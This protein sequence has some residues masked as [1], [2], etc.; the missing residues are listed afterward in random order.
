MKDYVISYSAIF[1]MAYGHPWVVQ[2][3]GSRDCWKF[4]TEAEA[5]DFVGKEGGRLVKVVCGER[6]IME[7]WGKGRA[8]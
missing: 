6:D 4:A 1:Q 3:E 7:K 8:V 5:R 2:C